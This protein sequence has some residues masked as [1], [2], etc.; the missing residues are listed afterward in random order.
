[1]TVS[2]NTQ[3]NGI[4]SVKALLCLNSVRWLS[5]DM[6]YTKTQELGFTA[7]FEP[8]FI[9]SDALITGNSPPPK[10]AVHHHWLAEL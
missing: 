6:L 2:P 1:M 7:I 9:E 3:Y 5:S 10:R 8:H 4:F